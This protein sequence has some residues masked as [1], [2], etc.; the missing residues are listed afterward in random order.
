MMIKETIPYKYLSEPDYMEELRRETIRRK[1]NSKML[2]RY[3]SE[4]Q[5][6]ISQNKPCVYWDIKIANLLDDKNP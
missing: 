5:K 4:R 6:C 3:R 2:N 1:I